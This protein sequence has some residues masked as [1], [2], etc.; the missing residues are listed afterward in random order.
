MFYIEFFTP[1]STWEKN[2]FLNLPLQ[3]D[4]PAFLYS[5]AFILSHASEIFLSFMSFLILINTHINWAS[6]MCQ[7]LW[8]VLKAQR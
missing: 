7:S 8:Q 3:E 1:S 2:F 5:S 6:T 4:K